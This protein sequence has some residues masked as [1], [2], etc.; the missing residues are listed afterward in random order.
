[1]LRLFVTLR[2][3]FRLHVD[4]FL[5]E[6]SKRMR[7]TRLH[8][9]F[10]ISRVKLLT[11]GIT[12]SRH[13]HISLLYI[14]LTLS[15]IHQKAGG[16]LRS[17]SVVDVYRICHKRIVQ[18]GTNISIGPTV[19]RGLRNFEPSRGICPHAAAEFTHFRGISR[20]V[21]KRHCKTE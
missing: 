13:N 15:G 16:I 17:D 10:D 6:S 3:V 11:T 8:A 4:L 14:G 21:T 20:K 19:F 7:Y 5:R 9:R 18:P 12:I 1:M 2:T